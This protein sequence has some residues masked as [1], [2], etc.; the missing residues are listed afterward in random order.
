MRLVGP[1]GVARDLPLLRRQEPRELLGHQRI[2]GHVRAR[3]HQPPHLV[4]V[5][6]LLA[7]GERQGDHV[8]D[9]APQLGVV[10][11]RDRQQP[12]H[13]L[14]LAFCLRR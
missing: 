6:E 4:D 3:A 14:Q 9:V 11:A 2:V 5:R 13:M 1:I 12:P 10:L 7:L 8:A